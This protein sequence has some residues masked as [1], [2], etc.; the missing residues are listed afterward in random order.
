ME[1]LFRFNCEIP[2]TNIPNAKITI[3]SF[4]K[5]EPQKSND[6]GSAIAINEITLL[7]LKVDV[8][9]RYIPIN[10]AKARPFIIYV[11]T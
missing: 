2:K 8:K 9:N 5:P 7:K 3:P 11:W 10:P 6:G 1:N 4:N